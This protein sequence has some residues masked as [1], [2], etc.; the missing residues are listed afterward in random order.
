[1]APG[2][3]GRG[4]ES[5]GIEKPRRDWVRFAIFCSTAFAGFGRAVRHMSQTVTR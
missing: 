5:Q 4:R 1:M 2:G 3:N